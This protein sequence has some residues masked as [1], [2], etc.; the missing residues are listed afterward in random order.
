MR[1]SEAPHVMPIWRA[2]RRRSLRPGSAAASRPTSCR[3]RPLCKSPFAMADERR[4]QEIRATGTKGW[5]SCNTGRSRGTRSRR[6]RPRKDTVYWDNELMGFG[7]RVYPSETKVYMVQSRGPGGLKRVTV[8]RHGVIS[9]DR[10]RRRAA[11]IIARIKAGEAPL[12]APMA[13]EA[14]GADGGRSRGAVFS[15]ACRG[16][17][18]TGHGEVAPPCGAQAHPCPGSASCPLLR[19]GVNM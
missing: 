12:A 1:I 18:Q 6:S 2:T 4:T 9:A 3:R 19:S 11:L 16:A 13:R 17:L 15:R 10:A 8:G 14:T 5:R 7:V